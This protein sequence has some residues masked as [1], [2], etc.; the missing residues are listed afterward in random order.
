MKAKDFN[1]FIDE[2]AELLQISGAHDA[3]Q[4]W[5][6]LSKVFAFS[7]DK[8]VSQMLKSIDKIKPASDGAGIALGSMKLQCAKLKSF[9]KKP[10]KAAYVNDL[11]ALE[12]TLTK[13][14]HVSFEQFINAALYALE[15]EEHEKLK[16]QDEK[17]EKLRKQQELVNDYTEKL[18][19]ALRDEQ[20][21]PEI[22]KEVSKLKVADIKLIA[23][24]FSGHPASKLKNKSIAIDAINDRHQAL[25]L[26]RRKSEATGDNIAA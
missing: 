11:T 2:Y 1:Q 5:Q 15:N 24:K 26:G 14:E 3:S 22:V 17:E 12:K 10:A 6:E 20:R 23:T 16:K 19:D 13:F 4:R 21:F 8:T 7:P 25:V 9:L 18:L